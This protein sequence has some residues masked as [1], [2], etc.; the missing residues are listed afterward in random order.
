MESISSQWAIEFALT[1]R[2]RQKRHFAIL[3]SGSQRPCNLALG[4]L[5][6]LSPRKKAW[7]HLLKED[8]VW[9]K[10]KPAQ[11]SWISRLPRESRGWGGKSISPAF[12]HRCRFKTCA[13]S[14]PHR[15]YTGKR[16]PKLFSRNL[17]SAVSILSWASKIWI[18]PMTSTGCVCVCLVSI[19]TYRCQ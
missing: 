15:S 2:R 7:A 9:S 8:V 4:L 11:L 12:T 14:K 17:E 13:S 19:W 16:L 18:R 1:C 6:L 10:D 5:G 3:S